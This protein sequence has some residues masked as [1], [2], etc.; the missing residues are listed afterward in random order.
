M[1]NISMPDFSTQYVT[2]LKS[3]MHIMYTVKIIM[4]LLFLTYRFK[5]FDL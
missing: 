4:T 2:S 3:G 5:I 1:S